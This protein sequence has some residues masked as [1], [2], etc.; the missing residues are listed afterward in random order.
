MKRPLLAIALLALASVAVAA[1]KEGAHWSQ[2]PSTCKEFR[3]AQRSQEITAAGRNIRSWVAGY[4]SAYNRQTADTYNILGITEFDSLIESI[5]KY[6]K[7]NPFKNVA[8]AME[9]ITDE[10]HARRYR[11]KREAGR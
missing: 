5:D 6:C 2:R 4:I 7:T 9:E 8:E 10:L 11:T 1:D 3:D